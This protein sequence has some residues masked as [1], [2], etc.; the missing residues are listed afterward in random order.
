MAIESI[1][2][3]I[4]AAKADYLAHAAEL[5]SVW[6]PLSK[7]VHDLQVA[8]SAAITEGAR[9]CRGCGEQP[10][11][12]EQPKD[13]GPR[14][15]PNIISIYEIGCATRCDA[16]VTDPDRVKSVA[17]WNAQHGAVVQ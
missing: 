15:K 13:I 11:G 4:V 2:A 10:L 6:R 14:G 9:P 5:E 3:S 17:T 16:R 8:L 7:K 1:K 12:I